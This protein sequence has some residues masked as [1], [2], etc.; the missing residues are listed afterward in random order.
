MK[1]IPN[2][3]IF[4]ENIFNFNVIKISTIYFV[5]NKSVV[6]EKSFLTYLDCKKPEY[7][8]IVYKDGAS[9]PNNIK[10]I[11]NSDN[12]NFN[13]EKSKI[14]FMLVE[15]K[16]NDDTYVINLSNN[17]YNFYV[18][19]N[20]F[21]KQFFL[22]Y[23]RYFHPDKVNIDEMSVPINEISLKIIDDNVDIKKMYF[24]DNKNQYIKLNETD[25][26]IIDE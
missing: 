20:I 26:S 19:D 21:D 4:L 7:D 12:I 6:L 18:K 8:F 3:N 5:K 10:I 13:Y 22:Y 11:H 14:K 24:T 1:Y 9:K 25:Y 15:L 17:S 16:I 23:L 2:I